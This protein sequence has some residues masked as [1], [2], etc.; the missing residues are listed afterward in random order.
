MIKSERNTSLDMRDAQS[1]FRHSK[2]THLLRDSERRNAVRKS[3]SVGYDTALG[4]WVWPEMSGG[5]EEATIHSPALS[6]DYHNNRIET[7]TV[8]SDTCLSPTKQRNVDLVKQSDHCVSK[9]SP[10]SVIDLDKQYSLQSNC[11]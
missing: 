3:K 2:E 8:K 11:L 10:A 9:K 4:L 6:T 5:N 7:R 1:M